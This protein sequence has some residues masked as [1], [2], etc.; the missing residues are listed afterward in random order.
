MV[1]VLLLKG[2]QNH[3][4]GDIIEVTNN[5]AFGLVDNGV[6]RMSQASDFVKKTELGATKAFANPPM[7]KKQKFH[8]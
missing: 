5:I 6:A 3:S 2:Y 8:K 1:K 7:A 4:A